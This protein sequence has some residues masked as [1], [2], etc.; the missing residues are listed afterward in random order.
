VSAIARVIGVEG[1]R[2]DGHAR[3]Q[4]DALRQVGALLVEVGATTAAYTDGILARERSVSTFMGEEV[5]IPHG[6]DDSRQHVLRAAVVLIRFPDGV[7]WA[8]HRVT[9]CFGIAS[10]SDEHVEV[11][12]GLADVLMDPERAAAL[13]GATDPQQ[14][15][16]LLT[17]PA[18]DE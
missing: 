5:A 17:A 14:V 1:I 8:G 18:D 16:D 13:R 3:D 11:L 4:Q 12:A 6:T 15:L 9:L 10:T 2:L 7:D